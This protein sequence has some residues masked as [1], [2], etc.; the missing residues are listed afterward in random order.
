MSWSR[1]LAVP[2]LAGLMALAA[3]GDNDESGTAAGGGAQQSDTASVEAPPTSPPT[4]IGVTEPL[5]EKPPTGKKMIWLQCEFP[6][7]ARTPE[8]I[9][10]GVDA[11]GWEL[12]TMAFKASAPGPSLQQAINR[13]PDYIAITGI[14]SAQIPNELAEADEAGIPVLS[15]G[16]T[17][18]PAE[19]EYAMQCGGSLA[20][21]AEYLA[22]W[23]VNDS[24]GKANVAA[25]TMTQY[26]T[27]NTETDWMKKNFSELCPDCTYKQLNL[28]VEDA[29]S[30]GIPS[31]VVAFLQSNPEVNY[32]FVT[33]G[34]LTAGLPEALKSAG[35]SDKVKIVGAVENAGVI[36]GVASGDFAAWTTEPLK[37]MGMVL[38]DGAARLSVGEELTTEYSEQTYRNPTYVVDSPEAA[39]ALEPTNNA[40]D[41][42]EGFV[43]QFKELWKVGP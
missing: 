24:G 14:P 34:D 16:T 8:G 26:D 33:L 15:C 6:A 10:A 22:R 40:W 41:G 18:L 39:N 3:C 12:E 20:T 1:W 31:K 13:K 35:Q 2:L 27:L 32:L 25:A 38:V 28:T 5:P 36:Q 29:G 9:E 30:G 43:E 11:L 4:E 7:C 21:A 42:P 37:Y 19:G 23:M 17:D